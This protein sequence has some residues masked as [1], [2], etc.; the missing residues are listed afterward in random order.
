MRL[1]QR[2]RDESGASALEFALIAPLLVLLFFGV[3]ELSFLMKDY[4]AMGSTVRAG[5]RAASAAADAGPGTCDATGPTPPPCTPAMAPALAQVAA[6]SMQRSGRAIPN[7]DI[8]WV[9]IYQAGTNG[10]PLGSSSLTC[11]S[12]N[13][14]KY[15]WD[16]GAS[17][18]RYASGAWNS[19]SV[20]ACLN[21]PGRMSVGVGMEIDHTWI[22]G[23]GG[24]IFGGLRQLQ[25][26]TVFQFEPLEQDRCKPGTPNAHS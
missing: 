14:V 22:T 13:C 18:F 6:D 16:A 7:D 24:D 10:F 8:Q 12:G 1:F 23:L 26:H 25:E 9:I 3:M 5:A 20:N 11:G 15:V 21:D 2:R 17:K 4:V 19:A